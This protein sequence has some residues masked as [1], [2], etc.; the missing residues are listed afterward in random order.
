METQNTLDPWI[1]IVS[2]WLLACSQVPA[3]LHK[4]ATAQVSFPILIGGGMIDE[5]VCRYVGADYWENDAMDG[6]RLCR[7]W[8]EKRT[9][10]FGTS[11]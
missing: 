4:A 5:Q 9:I 8:W 2:G 11:K 6:V 1:D 3:F 7:S 10:K